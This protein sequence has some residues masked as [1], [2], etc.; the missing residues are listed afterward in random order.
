MLVHY[1][2]RTGTYWSGDKTITKLWPTW[3][4]T[5]QDAINYAAA[6][7]RENQRVRKPGS[8]LPAVAGST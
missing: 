7:P 5:V 2:N 4:A 1:Y 8:P 6:D 3:A